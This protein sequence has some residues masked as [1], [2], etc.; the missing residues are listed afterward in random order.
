MTGG[1]PILGNPRKPHIWNET[2]RGS[3]S[4]PWEFPNRSKW[5]VDFQAK[6]TIVRKWMMTKM[7]TPVLGNLRTGGGHVDFVHQFLFEKMNA[8]TWGHVGVGFLMLVCWVA[9]RIAWCSFQ[10]MVFYIDVPLS[11]SLRFGTCLNEENRPRCQDFHPHD[12]CVHIGITVNF[13]MHV[14]FLGLIV[15]YIMGLL[16][17]PPRCTPPRLLGDTKN[18]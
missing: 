13:T 5:R 14:F 12:V 10:M 2:Q 18:Y 16:C 6:S 15:L 11:W 17:A 7:G 4:S 9:S 3:P 8:F 1:S